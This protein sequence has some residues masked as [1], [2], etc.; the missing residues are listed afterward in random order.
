[1]NTR[2]IWP[3]V[4][5]R[6]FAPSQ[7]EAELP[8]GRRLVCGASLEA[9]RETETLVLLQEVSSTEPFIF[10]GRSWEPWHLPN[11]Y[12]L[13]AA[14]GQSEAFI[15]PSGEVEGHLALCARQKRLNAIT[16]VKFTR[17]DGSVG[18]VYGYPGT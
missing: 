10:T 5:R 7:V 16:V 8:S 2:G 18:T 4:P 14:H 1:M 15:H 13:G 12:V 17:P 6:Q 11:Q 3:V 9:L